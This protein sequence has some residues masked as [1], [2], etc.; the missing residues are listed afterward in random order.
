MNDLEVPSLL[1][2]PWQVEDIAA[3]SYFC[4]PECIYKSQS[5]PDFQVHAIVNHPNSK[6]FFERYGDRYWEEHGDTDN[7]EN[8]DSEPIQVSYLYLLAYIFMED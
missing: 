6:D 5:V 3:F 4:C 8:I 1:I 2:N 7:F